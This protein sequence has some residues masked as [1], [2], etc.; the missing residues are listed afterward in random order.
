[1]PKLSIDPGSLVDTSHY[2]LG[3]PHYTR[4][5]KSLT[6]PRAQLERDGA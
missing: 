4:Y 1:M 5:L 6:V 3:S 2:P